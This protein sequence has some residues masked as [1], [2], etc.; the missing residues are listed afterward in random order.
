MTGTQPSPA[1]WPL[2]C[3]S[4]PGSLASPGLQ[5]RGPATEGRTALPPDPPGTLPPAHSQAKK[6]ASALSQ[7]TGTAQ[8]TVPTERWSVSPA[9]PR[10]ASFTC[11]W[12]GAQCPCA[13]KGLERPHCMVR[14]SPPPALSAASCSPAGVGAEGGPPK[15]HRRAT[16]LSLILLPSHLRPGL[17][18]SLAANC[19]LCGASQ[20]CCPN[21]T[22]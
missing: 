11:P 7:L 16:E 14:P 6:E 8:S 5:P 22:C 1:V 15:D 12:T 21:H 20:G 17:A 18:S 13:P 4:R 3:K 2:S 9:G 10:G 19:A